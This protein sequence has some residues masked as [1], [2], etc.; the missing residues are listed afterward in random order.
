[1]I[2]KYDLC[3]RRKIYVFANIVEMKS[4]RI[5]SFVRKCGKPIVNEAV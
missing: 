3:I 5:Q 2:N 4:Q 1:M